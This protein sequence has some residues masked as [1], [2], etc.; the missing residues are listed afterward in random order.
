MTRSSRVQFGR[1]RVL[2]VLVALAAGLLAAADGAAADEGGIEDEPPSITGGEVSPAS[3]PHEG[4]NVQISADVVDAIGVST[5]FAQIYGPDGFSQNFQLFAGDLDTYYGTLEV[6]GNAAE[7]SVLYE[8]EIQVYDLA[9]N[10]VASTIGGVEVEGTPQFD[11]FPYVTEATLNPSF[12]PA[13]G[14]TVT[15]GAEAGDNR[16]ISGIYASVYPAAG[17]VTEVPLNAVSF[18]RFEGTLTVPANAGPLAAEYI[19]EVVVQDDIGQESRAGAGTITVE[20]PPPPPSLGMLELWPTDR[21]FGT[22][23]VGRTAQRTVFVRNLPRRRG[24][25]V[26]ATARITGSPAFSLPGASS[27]FLHFV[28]APG[29]RKALDV[30]FR[31]TAVG[32]QSAFLEVVRDDGAQPGLTVSLSGRGRK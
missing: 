25:P 22:V 18:N 21:T 9:N 30:E 4:G 2:A 10:Y 17:G 8:V 1:V 23:A 16:S 19:V 31:P 12:L 15:I 29:A 13:E 32:L 28:L 3:L 11:E 24:G 5:V 6:P 7:F 14:G 27:G 20:A 26:E